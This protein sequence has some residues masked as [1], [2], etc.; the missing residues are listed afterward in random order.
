MR[1]I[2]IFKDF[3][4]SS[5]EGVGSYIEF[6]DTNKPFGI[7]K[8]VI[9]MRS[10]SKTKIKTKSAR[11]DFPRPCC[12]EVAEYLIS[13]D[14]LENYALQESELDKF[15]YRTYLDNKN[16]DDILVKVSA[17]NNFYSTNIFSP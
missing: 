1:T 14:Q 10:K 8:G 6:A 16:I 15:F 17:L 2:K 12:D 4:V 3:L 11:P 13:S 9:D 5:Y 7:G